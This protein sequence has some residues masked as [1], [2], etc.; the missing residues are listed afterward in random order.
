MSELVTL[1]HPKLPARQTIQVD[2]RRIGARLAAGW[3]VAPAPEPETK[4][5]PALEPE[6]P[7]RPRRKTS[8]DES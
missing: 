4:S 5:E 3:E 2:R 7:R 8:E 6:K 1:R